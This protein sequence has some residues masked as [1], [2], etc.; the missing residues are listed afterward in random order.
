MTVLCACSILFRVKTYIENG[1]D[2][3]L[4]DPDN[5]DNVARKRRRMQNED[6]E[7]SREVLL[8][9]AESDANWQTLA[10]GRAL[11]P[12]FRLAHMVT[13]F[14]KRAATDQREASDHKNINNQSFALFKLGHIQRIKVCEANGYTFLKAIC[15]PEMKKNTEYQVRLILDRN[16]DV[17]FASDGCPA[18]KGPHGSCKHLAAFCYA[19]EE[20]VRLG[21]TRPFFSCT[22]RLQTWNQPRDKKLKPQSLYNISFE[23]KQY[24]KDKRQS[25]KPLPDGYSATRLKYKRDSKEANSVLLSICQRYTKTGQ[26]PCAFMHVLERSDSSDAELVRETYGQGNVSVPPQPTLASCASVSQAEYTS[27]VPDIITP[28]EWCKS[29]KQLRLPLKAKAVTFCENKMT[30]AENLFHP[31]FIYPVEVPSRPQLQDVALEYYNAN[32]KATI[33]Q[34]REIEKATRGQSS[35][36]LWF[37]QRQIRLTASNFGNIVKR[38]KADVSKLTS[39]LTTTYNFLSDLRP[40]KYGKENEDV[41]AQLYVQYQHSHGSPG[42][43]V[44]NCGLVVN[45]NFPWLGASPDRVVHDPNATPSVGGLEVKCIESAQGLTPMEAYQMK[46][47]PTEGKKRC[48]CLKIMDGSLQLD[49]NHHYFYQVQGQQGVSGMEW[50]DFALLTD[51]CLGLGGL[52]VQRIYFQK[53]KWESEWLPK[54]TEFYFNHLLPVICQSTGTMQ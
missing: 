17:V 22:E 9:P 32:V 3:E 40:I 11:V 12:N 41:A 26:K 39:R 47:T 48:F 1:W 45:P 14:V 43:K 49:E 27:Q 10:K 52:H 31:P 50:V 23:R 36:G 35:S 7:E 19:L 30:N 13:Y 37:K 20:F 28:A 18:G 46:R 38:K 4:I 54:L 16:A 42:T 21:F 2:K 5:G 33:S 29:S 51:P 53:A 25:P 34:C 8:F 24:G 6:G 44:F 15:L